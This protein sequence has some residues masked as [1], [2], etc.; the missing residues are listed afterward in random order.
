ME[1][2]FLFAIL[3]V[4]A[5][6]FMLGWYTRGLHEQKLAVS[7]PTHTT[8]KCPRCEKTKT[9]PAELDQRVLVCNNCEVRMT[10]ATAL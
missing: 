4:G 2:V 8:W 6:M 5:G 7:V 9:L 3:A 1:T 10:R